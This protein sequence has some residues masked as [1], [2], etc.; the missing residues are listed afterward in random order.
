MR[1]F[2]ASVIALTMLAG[3]AS[4]ME[5]AARQDRATFLQCKIDNP[6]TWGDKCTGELAMYQ[7]SSSNASAEAARNTATAQ[8]IAGGLLAGAVVGAAAYAN[9]RPVYVAPAPVVYVCRWN[10]W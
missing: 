4:P 10:C 1:R 3:C 5:Q 7:T 8:A 2:L 9:S 6:Y